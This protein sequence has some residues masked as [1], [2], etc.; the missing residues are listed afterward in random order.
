MASSGV[1]AAFAAAQAA[2]DAWAVVVDKSRVVRREVELGFDAGAHGLA[3]YD[4]V[5]DYLAPYEEQAS[6]APLTP[7]GLRWCRHGD[8]V[9]FEMSRVLA[10]PYDALV[11]RV[12]VA[13]AIRLM[14]DYVGGASVV[15]T[16]DEEGRVTRQAER[17][18]YLPQP[19]WMVLSGG[20]YID[21]CKLEVVRYEDD[22]RRIAWRTISS[23]NGSAVHDDGTVTLERLDDRRSRVTVRGLQQFTLPPFWAA[24]EPYLA[25]AVKD[26]L[27]EDSY[28]RFFS[29]TLDNVEAVYEGREHRVGHDHEPADDEPLEQ[30]LRQT[31]QV[32]RGLLPERPVDQLARQWRERTAPAPDHVDEHGFRYFSGAPGRATPAGVDGSVDAVLPAPAWWSAIRTWQSEWAEVVAADLTGPA[33][34]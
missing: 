7:S 12:D 15:V 8:A 5:A 25:P 13:G 34:G 30:R 33:G 31:W 29:A 32:L 27:V 19:N 10:A 4:A 24:A 20:Q 6:R 9:L 1:Q 11:A 2:A 14:Y 21:V 3:E 18:L 16:R 17:N 26:A 23:P 28:R 22:W